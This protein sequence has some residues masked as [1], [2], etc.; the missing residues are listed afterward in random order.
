[1][2][3]MNM[4]R[5][6]NTNHFLCSYKIQKR[7][8]E[9]CGFDET[10]NMQTGKSVKLHPQNPFDTNLK[11]GQIRLLS[12]LDRITYVVLLRRWEENAFV[13]MTFSHYDFPATDEEFKPQ[14]DGG[15]Y[16]NTLQ[17]WNTRTLQDETLKKSWLIGNLPA[18]D[19]SDAWDFWEHL[20][21][22]RD[23]KSELLEKT[24]LPIT[25]SDDPRIQYMKEELAAFDQLDDAE[26]TEESDT[27]IWFNRIELPPL[28]QEE[29][30]A[31]AAGDEKQDFIAECTP[32]GYDEFVSIVFSP[33]EKTLRVNI[34]TAD[35][36]DVSHT[37]DS[38]EF[39]SEDCTVLA[40]VHDG[41][42][43]VRDVESFDGKC[44]LRNPVNH[45]VIILENIRS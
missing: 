5:E 39:I 45:S 42:C 35:Q 40:S 22:G 8:S 38:W 10:Q 13:V 9:V 18:S 43:I 17:A 6:K 24:G 30:I 32:Y 26:L 36:R 44:A 37:F 7:M 11:E 33:R 3:D 15:M 31:L 29:E 41:F 12:Q 21:T 27:A 20:M 25:L 28:W 19:C 34:Y 2:S 4:K 1:M 16:L 23:L 14:F